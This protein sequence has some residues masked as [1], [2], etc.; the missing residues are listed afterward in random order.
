MLKMKLYGMLL[1]GVG[2]AGIFAYDQHDKA[3]NYV[4]VEAT[5]KKVVETCYLETRKLVT[6]VLPC[7]Q[8]EALKESHPKYKDWRLKRHIRAEVAFKS[9][10]DD[11]FHS[12]ELQ[13]NWS[14]GDKVPSSG[15][16][17]KIL[18]S[19]KEAERVRNP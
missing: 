2:I 7:K 12:S 4:E 1:V 8:A 14:E 16:H 15:Q 3:T 18:A 9:P 5:V 6:D 17:M 10:V 13:L 11:S 19:L